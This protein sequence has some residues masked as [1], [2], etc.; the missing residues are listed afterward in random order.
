MSYFDANESTKELFEKVKNEYF[1]ELL[2]ADF[3]LVFRDNKS[4]SKGNVVIASIKKPDKLLKFKTEDEVEGGYDYVIVID[5]NIYNELSEEDKIRI[6]RHQ[7]RHCDVDNEKDD[8]YRLK[9]HDVEDFY[10]EIEL[11]KDDP[12][13]KE[14]VNTI[15]ESVYDK[16]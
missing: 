8:P 6:F 4:S 11:N 7:L 10:E 13:W 12:R 15:A 14:R 1:P 2:N 16:E 5:G 9:D 3:F